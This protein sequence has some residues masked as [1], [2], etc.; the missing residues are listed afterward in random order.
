LLLAERRRN[1]S[2]GQQVV[3]HRGAPGCRNE[4]GAGG[5]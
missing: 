1:S 4:G 2:V 3:L 5:D